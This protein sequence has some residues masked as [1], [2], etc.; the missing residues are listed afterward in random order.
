MSPHDCRS[1]MRLLLTPTQ[2]LL[3]GSLWTQRAVN[4]AVQ[5]QQQGD[6]LYGITVEMLT[7]GGRYAD[8][9]TQLSFPINSLQLSSQLALDVFLSLPGASAPSFGS[10]LQGATEKYSNFIDRLW[11]DVMNHPDLGDENKQQM[12]RI[13]AFDNANKTAKQILASL[14]KGAGVEEM[15]SSVER[16]G[17]QKQNETVAAAVQ[18][19]VREVVQPLAAVVQ[20]KR[21]QRSDQPFRGTCFHCGEMGHS[22]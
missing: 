1:L 9:N 10:V 19:T 13:L 2:F 7:G 21:P 5:H 17:A 12:F 11:D 15:L 14:L 3:W 22:K 20:Q 16:A 6:P 8:L 4:A 18:S